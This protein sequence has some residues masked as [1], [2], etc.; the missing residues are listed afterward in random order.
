MLRTIVT[1]L[2]LALAVTAVTPAA[3][4]ADDTSDELQMGAQLYQELKDKGEI[5]ASSPLY[6]TLRPIAEATTRVVQPR[7]PYPVHWY[8][9]HE[10]QPNA[11]AAPGGNVY[12]VDS[13]FTFVHNREELE[14]TLCHETSHLLYHDPLTEARRDK[15]IEG[16]ELFATLLFGGG[17]GTLIAADIIGQLDSNHYSREVEER[18]DLRGSDTC[19]AANSNPW[20]LVWLMEDFQNS[21]LKQPPEFLSDHPDDQHRIA[22][23]KQHFAQNPQTFARFED[24]RKLATPLHIP[25]NLAETF[26]H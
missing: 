20:G 12:V 5:V 23:L 8:I 6:D 26:V 16:R 13:L 15:E 4:R 9:V 3:A 14:G 11:F 2:V 19:A 7:L 22:A 1:G 10:G 17:L 21:D 24:N 25:K 18:A